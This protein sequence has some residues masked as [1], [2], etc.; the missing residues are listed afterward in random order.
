[1][2]TM[3]TA[4]HIA[5]AATLAVTGLT[6]AAP[7]AAELAAPA[8]QEVKDQ[9]LASVNAARAQYGARPLTWNETLYPSADEHARACRFQ[10][11]NPQG[12][13]GENM[14]AAS[15]SPD[16]KTAIANAF[17]AWMAEAS[18]Y[19]YNRP[20]FSASTGHFTQVVWKSTTQITLAVARCA[21]GTIFPSMA[22]TYVVAR[23]TP[24]GNLQGQFPQN[25]GRHV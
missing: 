11:S 19:N 18:Q 4:R 2:D 17:N 16:T 25:V 5:V 13:Y 1:M 7:A 15:G 9:T 20:G 8:P 10:H 6:Q 14:Y 3:R 22:S 12:A 21:A 23:F 24:P